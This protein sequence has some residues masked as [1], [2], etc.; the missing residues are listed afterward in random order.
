MLEGHIFHGEVH[1]GIMR[2]L[3]AWGGKGHTLKHG[4]PM[5]RVA[6]YST[7]TLKPVSI[8]LGFQGRQEKF[9]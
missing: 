7:C 2:F 8:S 3:G 4:G 1:G 9:C 5:W 6:V